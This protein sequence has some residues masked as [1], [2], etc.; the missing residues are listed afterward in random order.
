MVNGLNLIIITIIA[1]ILFAFLGIILNFWLTKRRHITVNHKL[2]NVNIIAE[3]VNSDQTKRY[4]I[5]PFLMVQLKVV[6]GYDNRI[7][8]FWEPKI[9]IGRDSSCNLILD[10]VF[11]S[12]KHCQIIYEDDKYY[13]IDLTSTNG[14]LINGKTINQKTE[15]N[16]NDNI[17]LGHINIIFK[18]VS[19]K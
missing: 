15:L 16:T 2:N 9:L 13:L 17:K 8:E 4:P 3:D 5:K 7:W 1:S 19:M 18:I 14:T 11:I 6:D 12:R 10:S